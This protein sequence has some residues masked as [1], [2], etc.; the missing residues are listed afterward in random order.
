MNIQTDIVLFQVNT[1]R[2]NKNAKYYFIHVKKLT[3][4]YLKSIY[5]IK[6]IIC[7]EKKYDMK[8]SPK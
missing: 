2:V 4:F 3:I 8:I 5:I 1:K 7:S 6:K